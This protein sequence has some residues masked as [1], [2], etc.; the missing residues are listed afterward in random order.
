MSNTT[1]DP[2]IVT[3]TLIQRNLVRYTYPIILV[4]GN[5][6]SFLNILVLTQR[7]YLEK[8]SSCYILASTV[9][10]ILFFSSVVVFRFLATGFG[11]DMTATSLFYCIFQA[12]MANVTTSLS[13]IYLVLACVDRWSMTSRSVQFRS[14]SQMKVA[15]ILIPSIAIFWFVISIHIIINNSIIGGK[16]RAY[17]SFNWSSSVSPISD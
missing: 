14:F 16:S 1:S 17:R 6:G 12:Y 3:I 13:R 4:F 2:L 9:N 10:N 5:I 7:V 11:I 8:P 15:K